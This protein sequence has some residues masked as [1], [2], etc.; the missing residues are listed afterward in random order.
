MILLFFLDKI[1]NIQGIGH[2]KTPLKSGVR[3]SVRFATTKNAWDEEH[4]PALRLHAG[5]G[6]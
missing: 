3:N 4:V 2:K 5:C 1:T 6:P